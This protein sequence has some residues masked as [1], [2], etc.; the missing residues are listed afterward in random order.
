M[1]KIISILA[2]ASV[3]ALS[4]CD[5]IINEIFTVSDES[6]VAV[7]TESSTESTTEQ[8]T[9][10][11]IEETVPPETEEVTTEEI[12]NDYDDNI[13]V[14]YSFRTKNQL[15]QH[16]EKHGGEFDGD[17]DYETAEEYESGANDVINNPD[18]LYKTEKEDGDGVYYLE[19]TNEFVILS[20]DGYIRTYFRPTAGIDY[21]NR[22]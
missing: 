5:D 10:L 8:E 14:E 13:E 19:S 22:Q 6:S 4:G 12:F 15:E 20:T 7:V 2:I 3:L 11:F 18:A 21:F 1:K 9:K 16:F 17:F